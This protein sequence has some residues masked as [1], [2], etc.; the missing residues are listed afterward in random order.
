[1][2]IPVS[3]GLVRNDRLVEQCHTPFAPGVVPYKMERDIV[4]SDLVHLAH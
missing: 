1:M 3:S 2:D 4:L